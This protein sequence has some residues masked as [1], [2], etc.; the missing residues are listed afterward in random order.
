MSFPLSILRT[1]RQNMLNL[2]GDLSLAQLNH[3]PTGFNNNLIW[4]LGHVI[5]TQQLLC[6]GLAKQPTTISKDFIDRYRKGTKP[7]GPVDGAEGSFIKDRL[8]ATVDQFEADLIRLDFSSFKSYATS[9]GVEL[10]NVGQGL[11][12]NN[13]HEGMHLGVMLALRK[14]V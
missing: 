4:N 7:N 10:N 9:Y 2:C 6:Y 13:T 5:A 14:L 1:S 8:F 12:F 3:I 11:S